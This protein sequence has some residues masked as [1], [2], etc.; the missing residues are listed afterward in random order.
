MTTYKVITAGINVRSASNASA[1]IVQSMS[2]NDRFEGVRD[3]TTN[4][5]NIS[6]IIR[7]NGNIF[8]PVPPKEWWCN[9]SAQFVEEIS[10]PPPPPTNQAPAVNAGA[11]AAITLP[12][13]AIL[14]GLVT[15][16]NLPSG[17]LSVQWSK[18][19]GPGVVTFTSPN[20]VTTSASF[21]LPGSYVLRLTANDGAL[22]GS[23]DVAV[24]V[25]AAPVITRTLDITVAE[26]GWQSVTVSVVQPK[27]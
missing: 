22:S 7:V 13:S 24:T 19:S 1:P 12:A 18:V 2:L 23:D 10:A 14:S 21:S 6:K 25:A 26:A 11:D 17:T 3:L 15:D 9:G 16:D 5:I 8:A 20:A 4:W 27:L